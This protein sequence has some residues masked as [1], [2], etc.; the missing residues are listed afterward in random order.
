MTHDLDPAWLDQQY[1]NRARVP[2]HARI[3]EGWQRRSAL[4]RQRLECRLDLRYGDAPSETLDV[5]PSARGGSAPVLVFIHGGYWRSLDKAD[6]S[7]VAPAFVDAGVTVA[8]PNYSLCPAV[9]IE[10]IAMQMARALA[11][12]ARN[13]DRLGGDAGRIAVAGH[14]AGGH[15]AAM[16]MTCDWGKVG[17]DLPPDL[18]RGALAI[19][20]LFEL[21][22]VRR[23]PFLQADLRLTPASARRL[24]PA[25]MPPPRRGVLNAVAGGDESDEFR[26]QT[27]AIR[28][29]WGDA[30]VPVCEEVAGAN[31]FDILDG[32]A[33]PEGRLHRLA[34]ALCGKGPTSA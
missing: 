27:R 17:D 29:A 2:D 10:D 19:S 8:V 30:A 13:A 24:S 12:L 32:L 31:H 34:L 14:S 3:I 22:P 20:G 5:F 11:W 23:T 15:L 25:S 21:E 26:R 28:D 16:L 18:L 33:D 6:H 7:F 4:A 1:N 9:S